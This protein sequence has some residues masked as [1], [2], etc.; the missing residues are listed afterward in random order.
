MLMLG[1]E[2]RVA[3]KK[4]GKDFK[5]AFGNKYILKWSLWWA[6]GMC[7][8]FQVRK[9]KGKEINKEKERKRERER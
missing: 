6:L 8:N 5:E 1:S 4:V 7:G 9:I 3:L 2:V